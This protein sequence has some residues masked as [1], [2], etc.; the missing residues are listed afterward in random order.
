MK[1]LNRGNVGSNGKLFFVDTHYDF[2]RAQWYSGEPIDNEPY[3]K[4]Y[5]QGLKEFLIHFGVKRIPTQNI[6]FQF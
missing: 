3:Y 5:I 2:S 4:I 1:I 6:I